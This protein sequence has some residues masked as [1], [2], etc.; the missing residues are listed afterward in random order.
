M[1]KRMLALLLMAA[2]TTG[3]CAM[4][5]DPAYTAGDPEKQ[6]AVHAAVSE[7]AQADSGQSG[8]LESAAAKAEE[9]TAAVP[10]TAAGQTGGIVRVQTDSAAP[11][12]APV[13]TPQGITFYG[14][15]K[16]V[17][18]GSLTIQANQ[19][20]LAGLKATDPEEALMFLPNVSDLE[21]ALANTQKLL[22][23]V[24][25]TEF[26][27]GDDADA[28]AKNELL[29]S[30]LKVGL[31]NTISQ[32]QS[33][34]ASVKSSKESIEKAVDQLEDQIASA[35][36]SFGYQA[37]M[38]VY[39]AETTYITVASLRQT[40]NDVQRGLQ[41]LDRTIE[42][43][44][45]RYQLGQ[46]SQ[47][48]L[49]QVKSQRDATQSQLQTLLFNIQN[50]EQGL[51]MQLGWEVGTRATVSGLVPVSDAQ[52]RGM[53]YEN[54]L[55]QART[56]SFTIWQANDTLRQ[57]NNDYEDDVTSTQ[58]MV[59]AAK[60]SKQ[61]A[62]RTV[63]QNFLGLFNAVNEKKRLVDVANRAY[64]TQTK[65]YNAAVKQHELG[66]LSKNALLSAEDE[67]NTAKSAITSAEYDLF[68]AYNQYDWAKRGVMAS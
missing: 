56:N 23:A 3:L 19:K 60:L 42:E 16:T 44:E 35:E 15:D 45:T 12:T 13:T 8:G 17:R 37:D 49:E 14:I 24:G 53:N 9:Q 34:I 4:A 65:T 47:L 7:E 10:Q 31:N 41:S 25:Q 32:L 21:A 27:G 64:E 57:A 61:Q 26:I 48:K 54:D 2:M 36:R 40:L 6:D 20:T 67:L 58:H 51:A 68:L 30:S 33:S 28:A 46:I 22:A 43:M 50:A 5:I 11:D 1:K 63:T 62:E 59:E 29:V 55:K 18:A 66:K 38:L 52:L 39:S